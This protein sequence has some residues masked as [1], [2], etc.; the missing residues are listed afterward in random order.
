MNLILQTNT[1]EKIIEVIAKN[2]NFAAGSVQ[3]QDSVCCLWLLL[4]LCETQIQFL[5]DTHREKTPSNKTQELTKSLNMNIW[6]LGA[7][8][9]LFVRGCYT[10]FII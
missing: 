9:Q 10:Q 7:L 6:V 3:V 8:N 4:V 1:F 2:R 5:K